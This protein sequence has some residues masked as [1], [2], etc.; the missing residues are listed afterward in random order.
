MVDGP[1]FRY[2]VRERVEIR[3]RRI[4]NRSRTSWPLLSRS[5]FNSLADVSLLVAPRHITRTALRDLREARVVFVHSDLATDILSDPPKGWRPRVLLI[6]GS[7]LEFRSPPGPLPD[8][9]NGAL[10]QN[11]F[12]SDNE[13]T[14]TLPIGL[15]DRSIG[16]NGLPHLFAP[17]AATVRQARLMFGPYSL[18]HPERSVLLQRFGE[19]DGPWDVLTQRMRPS[20]YGRV[21]QNYSHIA[22]VQGNGIDTHRAWEAIYRGAV[23]VV[24]QNSWSESLVHI[25]VPLATIASWSPEDVKSLVAAQP[26]LKPLVPRELSIMWMPYWEEFIRSLVH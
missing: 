17:P 6:A 12:I 1:S 25:G 22:A 9:V 10:I 15:E 19:A 4:I 21:S 16:I 7:D 20:V 26:E 13:R 2:S 3:V 5:A 14:W 8:S 18:T 11:S 24:L 23:P